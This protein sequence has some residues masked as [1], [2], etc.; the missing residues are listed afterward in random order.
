MRC[1]FSLRNVHCRDKFA[2]TVVL[3]PVN[4]SKERHPITRTNNKRMI[5]LVYNSGS[6][7]DEGDNK[8]TDTSN[9]DSVKITTTAV[10]IIMTA[11]ITIIVIAGVVN[12]RRI[13]MILIGMIVRDIC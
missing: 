11:L 7:N 9:I 13:F 2:L 12:T 8:N 6:N 1:P 3:S 10:I 4:M 5:I